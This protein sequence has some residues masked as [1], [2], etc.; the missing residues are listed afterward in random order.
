MHEQYPHRKYAGEH[1]V[2]LIV[3]GAESESLA[4]G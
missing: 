3:N 1:T 4:N 2:Y